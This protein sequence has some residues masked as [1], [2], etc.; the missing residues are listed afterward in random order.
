[1]YLQIENG[2][3][4]KENCNIWHFLK[5][6]IQH[7]IG[8]VFDFIRRRLLFEPLEQCRFVFQFSLVYRR[9]ALFNAI[10]KCYDNW[11]NLK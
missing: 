4:T 10:N 1:M 9:N 8:N 6:Q 7:F 2:N 11:W 3:L 5:Y